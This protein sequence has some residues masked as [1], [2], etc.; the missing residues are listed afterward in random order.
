LI[1]LVAPRRV[2]PKNKTPFRRSW[3]TVTFAPSLSRFPG[4]EHLTQK[5]EV[6]T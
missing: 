1:P 4:S 2:T 3:T 5:Y 6:M